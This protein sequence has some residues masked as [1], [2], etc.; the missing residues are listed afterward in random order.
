VAPAPEWHP[1]VTDDGVRLLLTRY[2]GGKKGPVI[3]V[4]GLGVSSLI[5]STDTIKTNVLEYLVEN[6]YD[7]WLLD[8]RASIALP[9][10]NF[11]SDGDQV[12][13]YDY[14]G[15]VAK[16]RAVTGANTVQFVVHCWGATTFFLSMLG[17]LQGVR[18]FV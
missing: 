10:S 4:H 9:A 6:G 15:A 13:K 18:S 5:F 8:F 2:R 12:A 11:L 14:P 1:F 7:V 3:L 16:V 17:G